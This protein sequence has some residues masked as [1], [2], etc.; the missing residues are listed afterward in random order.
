MKVTGYRCLQ[1]Y[2]DW[3][4]PVGDVNGFIA[5]GRTE[6]SIVLIET[7]IGILDSALWDLKAKALDEPLWRLLGARDRFVA[8]YASGLDIALDD[9]RL[10]GLY[11]EMA[12]RGFTSGKLKG[13]L[14]ADTDIRRL[15][16]VADELRRNTPHPGLMLDA[17]ESWNLKQAVRH[18]R[19]VE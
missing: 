11:R 15:G 14:D 18:V 17:N 5:S 6:I 2:H 3:G 10:A 4:R 1:T 19:R 8:G 13:G 16:I 9:E 7:E 12:T